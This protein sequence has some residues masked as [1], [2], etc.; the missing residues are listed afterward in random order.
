MN[1]GIFVSISA[2]NTASS[3]GPVNFFYK[4]R[5]VVLFLRLRV[6]DEK[7]SLTA[8][9]SIDYSEGQNY[10]AE[11]WVVFCRRIANSVKATLNCI[12]HI[13]KERYGSSSIFFPCHGTSMV[14]VKRSCFTD[15][16]PD[17]SITK[18]FTLSYDLYL[19][20]L[21]TCYW[22]NIHFVLQK[23]YMI[24]TLWKS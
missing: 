9:N 19:S 6:F 18:S 13:S 3:G 24:F 7:L 8:K 21:C 16:A 10:C 11:Q 15:I 4:R 5:N 2:Q 23:L 12:S 1:S 17:F 22:E 14:A 20:V